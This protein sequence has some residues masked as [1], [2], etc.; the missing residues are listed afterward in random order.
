MSKVRPLNK[1]RLLNPGL[2]IGIIV[3]AGLLFAGG[4]VWFYS[5]QRKSAPAETPQ[6]QEPLPSGK[7]ELPTE[8]QA[9]PQE[10]THSGSSNQP[11]PSGPIIQITNL[12]Q[13]AN[14]DLL[15][16][17]KVTG[18]SSGTCQLSITGAGAVVNKSAEIIYQSSFSTCAGFTVPVSELTAGSANVRLTVLANNKEVAAD[19]KTIIIKK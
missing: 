16:Q 19:Q 4:A 7:T 1:K 9:T 8:K 5:N 11:T 3:V 2:L 12:T 6:T 18:V 10:K 17:T 13:Q 14:G 15:V